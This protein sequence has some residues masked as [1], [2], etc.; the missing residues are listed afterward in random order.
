MFECLNF[1]FVYALEY[2]S[3]LIVCVIV[4]LLIIGIAGIVII[5]CRTSPGVHV[6]NNNDT[7]VSNGNH[8]QGC[9]A[10]PNNA[11]G[12]FVTPPS[13]GGTSFNRIGIT[14]PNNVTGYFGTPPSS[15]GIQG[16]QQ[17]DFQPS[18]QFQTLSALL[19]EQNTKISKLMDE[20]KQLASLFTSELDKVKQDFAMLKDSST[21]K[22]KKSAKLPK[23]L[24]VY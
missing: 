10:P 7:L 20:N 22:T 19:E 23:S 11:A 8:F 5:Y 12:F 6:F 18:T 9:D 16:T 17:F 15:T 3:I 4:I 13:A 14:P 24:M 2:N 21:S 1:T